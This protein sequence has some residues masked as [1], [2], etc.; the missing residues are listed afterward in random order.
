MIMQIY[1][2]QMNVYTNQTNVYKGSM[3]VVEQRDKDQALGLQIL[4]SFILCGHKTYK[5]HIKSIA[6]FIHDDNWVEVSEGNLG[7]KEV[8]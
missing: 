4:E 1:K 6:I 7:I 2:G 3:A 8:I 5:M